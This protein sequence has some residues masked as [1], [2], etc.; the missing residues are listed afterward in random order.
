M[1][2]RLPNSV[3]V[4]IPRTGGTWLEAVLASMHIKHQIFK[5]DVDSHF[6]HS[7]LPPNWR[8]LPAFGF[9]RHP[10][11]WVKSRWSHLIEHGLLKDYRHFGIHRKFDECATES[12]TDTVNNILKFHPGLVGMTYHEMLLGVDHVLCTENLADGT[13]K[14]LSKLEDLTSDQL[15][16]IYTRPPNNSTS[17]DKKWAAEFNA[18]PPSLI[19]EFLESE[20]KTIQQWYR[21]MNDEIYAEN[22]LDNI[23]HLI[24]AQA[25]WFILGGPADANEA[26]RLHSIRPDIKILGCEPNPVPF[27]IQQARGFPGELL[28]IALW[29]HS[30]TKTLSIPSDRDSKQNHRCGSLVKYDGDETKIQVNA[31]SLDTLSEQYGPFHD[32]VLWLDIEESEMTCLAGA[33]GL[34][35][36]GKVLLINL[37]VFSYLEKPIGDFLKQYGFKEV[38]RWNIHNQGDRRWCDI[39][40]AKS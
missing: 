1:S 38:H 13:Y 34:L 26:Q 22:Q 21:F 20:S 25:K 17:K 29:D 27:Q 6:T 3:F 37:E 10:L 18:V 8:A 35:S 11:S 31:S 5:G 19:Q 32:C 28:P 39:V 7:Q 14:L 40:Y 15:E 23:K 4:H 16:C 36:S 2:V 30:C 24:P 9:I 33:T 12:F